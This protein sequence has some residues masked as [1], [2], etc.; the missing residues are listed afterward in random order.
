MKFSAVTIFLSTLCAMASA[1]PAIRAAL[2]PATAP[3]CGYPTV[4]LLRAYSNS[5]TAHFYT[6]NATEMNAFINGADHYISEGGVAQI[7]P[8]DTQA[9][10]AIP[11]FRLYG[12][13]STDYL[14]TANTTQRDVVLGRGNYV[15]QG[16]VGY[17]YPDQEC[18]TIP[19]YWL[20][21]DMD[22]ANFD[23]YTTDQAEVDDFVNVL[24]YTNEGVAGYVNPQ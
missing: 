15:S 8:S 3:D 5:T 2:E 21:K 10:T 7:L 23:F 24:G 6:T 9:P 14:Y 1:S 20:Y 12:A 19:L 22:D 16:V 11:L 4:P 13:K 17:V 18:G